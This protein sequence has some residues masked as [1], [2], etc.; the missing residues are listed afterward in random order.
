M[1]RDGREGGILKNETDQ[2]TG[3][4]LGRGKVEGDGKQEG[5]G[6]IKEGGAGAPGIEPGPIVQR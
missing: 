3:G 5:A 2:G 4:S 1:E 6:G